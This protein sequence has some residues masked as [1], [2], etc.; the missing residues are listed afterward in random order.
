MEYI[1][2]FTNTS[3]KILNR[4]LLIIFIL[5]IFFIGIGI[6]E[7]NLY[8]S[9]GIIVSCGSKSIPQGGIYKNFHNL[10]STNSIPSLSSYT[11]MG[12][13]STLNDCSSIVFNNPTQD[14]AKITQTTSPKKT[15]TLPT[16]SI[17]DPLGGSIGTS[18]IVSTLLGIVLPILYGLIG[19]IVLGL[20]S[21][22]GFLL[23]TSAGDSN[24]V[25]KAKS[26]LTGA[27][28]GAS[29]IILAYVISLV[30][31]HTL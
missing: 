16:G 25:E 29:I 30:L 5:L 20:I 11:D 2:L 21:Y 14:I 4:S 19:V 18:T 31:I 15:V 26:V 1:K 10:N 27:I 13:G 3:S 23:M 17:N 9:T 8:A 12:T 28:I 22:S 6:S 7:H 24:K